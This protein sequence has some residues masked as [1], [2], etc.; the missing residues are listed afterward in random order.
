MCLVSSK[1]TKV[2]FEQNI[3]VVCNYRLTENN[4]AINKANL[5][6]FRY[7]DHTYMHSN[8]FVFVKTKQMLDQ[9]LSHNHSCG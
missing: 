8:A 7:T 3:F 2:T 1:Y 6:T 9:R 5:V 4:F